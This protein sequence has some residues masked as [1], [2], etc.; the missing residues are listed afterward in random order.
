MLDFAS[1][2]LPPPKV[3]CSADHLLVVSY[4]SHKM[5]SEQMRAMDHMDI[6]TRKQA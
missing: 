5:H 2:V 4:M 3:L 6:S 1:A